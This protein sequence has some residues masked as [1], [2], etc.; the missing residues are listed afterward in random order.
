MLV[1]ICYNLA[2][3]R[4]W[5]EVLVKISQ[6]IETG[7]KCLLRCV[8]TRLYPFWKLFHPYHHHPHHKVVRYVTYYD[9]PY[10]HHHHSY[11]SYGDNIDRTDE[12]NT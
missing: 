1:L 5:S 6:H 7:L 9:D 2:A 11:D 12:L 3:H 10:S 4:N 8:I